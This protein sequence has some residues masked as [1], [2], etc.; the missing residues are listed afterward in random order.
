MSIMICKKCNRS[1]D[2]DFNADD[3]NDE[4]VCIYCEQDDIEEWGGV[5][6]DRI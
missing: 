4:G 3:I 2:T 1:I 6:P 5:I